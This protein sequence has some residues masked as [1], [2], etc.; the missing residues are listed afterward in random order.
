MISNGDLAPGFFDPATKAPRPHA[1][2][3]DDQRVLIEYHNH[4][5]NM[6]SYLFFLGCG[7]YESYDGEF[8]YCDGSTAIA[9]LLV[10]PKLVDLK[11]AKTAL[12]ALIDSIMWCYLSTGPEGTEHEVERKRI[13][14]LYPRRDALKQ[15]LKNGSITQEQ[16]KE[17]ADIRAELKKLISVWK[18]TGYAYTGK[19]KKKKKEKK[20]WK[21]RK[22]SHRLC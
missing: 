18:K 5:V 19:K 9:E 4:L 6:A 12:Q 1:I 11:H 10:F 17:L 13:Y 2:A 21:M 7:T 8:E 3:G 22:K 20:R 15:L 14:E 16:T